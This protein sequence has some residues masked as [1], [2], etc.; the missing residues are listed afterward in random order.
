VIGLLYSPLP[1]ASSS[2]TTIKDS[3]LAEKGNCTMSEWKTLGDIVTLTNS[4][5]IKVAEGIISVD[6]QHECTYDYCECSSRD[7]QEYTVAE[8]KDLVGVLT[9]AIQKAER[10]L[11]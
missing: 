11:S 2:P 8:A 4:T 3:I 5:V 1:V 9:E 7:V 6:Q 10:Q